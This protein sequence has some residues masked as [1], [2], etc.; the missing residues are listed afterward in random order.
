MFTALQ[1]SPRRASARGVVLDG[2]RRRGPWRGRMT[3]SVPR[4][5]LW[6]IRLGERRVR[7]GAWCEPVRRRGPRHWG[8]ARHPNGIGGS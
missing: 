8:E 3:T 1:S 4:K 5:C 7:L 2:S 6:Q